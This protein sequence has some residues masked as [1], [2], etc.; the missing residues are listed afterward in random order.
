MPSVTIRGISDEI[1]RRFKAL[2]ALRGISIQKALEEAMLLWIRQS[3]LSIDVGDVDSV[4]DFIRKNPAKPFVYNMGKEISSEADR[5][6]AEKKLG[7]KQ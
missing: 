3:S 5:K 2:A 1:Y 6:W 4:I 7:M